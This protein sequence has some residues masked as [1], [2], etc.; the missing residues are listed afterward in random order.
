[1]SKSINLGLNGATA[2][3]KSFNMK[4]NALI[5]KHPVINTANRP[6]SYDL[7]YRDW[8]NVDRD[9][10]KVKNYTGR[11][12]R[13]ILLKIGQNR[14]IPFP[15]DFINRAQASISRARKRT[16]LPEEIR[17]NLGTTSGDSSIEN[18]IDEL[19][20]RYWPK[21]FMTHRTAEK[22]VAFDKDV[23]I[24]KSHL[25]VSY[26]DVLNEIAKKMRTSSNFMDTCYSRIR[27]ARRFLG[28]SPA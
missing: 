23:N 28:L 16:P 5:R 7:S 10:L 24:L 6:T 8:I 26:I 20:E 3:R 17:T 13:E 18:I 25:K 21:D 9:L 11:P 12:K 4:V 1:M 19:T 15:P 22:W 27:N 14:R 2:R